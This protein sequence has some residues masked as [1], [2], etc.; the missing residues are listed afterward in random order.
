MNATHVEIQIVEP[1]VLTIQRIQFDLCEELRSSFEA[2]APEYPVEVGEPVGDHIVLRPVEYHLRVVVSNTP[3]DDVG[4]PLCPSDQ[5]CKTVMDMLGAARLTRK[6]I[7]LTSDL[8]N[9]AG[10]Y[11]TALDFGR[12]PQSAGGLPISLTLRHVRK[13]SALTI[14]VPK[15]KKALKH[16]MSRKPQNFGVWRPSTG[17]FE[18]EING[19]KRIW[20][21]PVPNGRL[22]IVPE[23]AFRGFPRPAPDDAPTGGLLTRSPATGEW[24]IPGK[25]YLPSGGGPAGSVQIQRNWPLVETNLL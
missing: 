17:I 7:V 12:S 8:D 6:E 1:D 11:I 22:T 21:G 14:L 4:W 24:Q 2:N 5:R 13:T 19:Q 9:A 23:E 16:K 25:A 18:G 15:V 20:S 10:L 3:M